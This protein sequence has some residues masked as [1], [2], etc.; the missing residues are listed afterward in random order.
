MRRDATRSPTRSEPLEKR[1]DSRVRTRRGSSTRARGVGRSGSKA[2][3]GCTRHSGSYSPARFRAAYGRER[4]RLSENN[5]MREIDFDS[6]DIVPRRRWQADLIEDV[7]P[8]RPGEW[9]IP[10]MLREDATEIERLRAFVREI[11]G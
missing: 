6:R 10:E 8:P 3:G 2:S 11:A 4:T 5:P 7:N 1:L 9:N